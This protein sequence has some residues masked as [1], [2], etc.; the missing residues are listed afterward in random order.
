MTRHSPF[1]AAI[2]DGNIWLKAT[3]EKLHLDDSRLAYPALRAAL[4]ALRD[5][6]PPEAA[7]HLSA[8]LPMIVRGLFFEGWKM[9][10]K[11]TPDNTVEE[12]CERL[13]G[14]LPPNYQRNPK[15]VAEAVFDV[16][17]QKL[18][19]GETAKVIDHFPKGLRQLWPS[20]ARR[21]SA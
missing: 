1:D 21:E 20:I 6:L 16:V 12:F 14:E 4:H 3:A 19:P 9:A 7:V 13:A 18:D 2:D 5:R 8:Q 15:M 11:P 10:G 17:W